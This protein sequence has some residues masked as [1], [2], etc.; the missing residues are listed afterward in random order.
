M[1][2][3][4]DFSV[5]GQ[6]SG[7]KL[8]D[9]DFDCRIEHFEL[10]VLFNEINDYK[11]KLTLSRNEGYSLLRDLCTSCESVENVCFEKVIT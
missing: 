5:K 10:Y 4:K 8:N 2:P 3:G 6:I 9:D 7:F 11:K 1:K